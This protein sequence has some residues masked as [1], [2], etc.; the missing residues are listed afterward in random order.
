MRILRRFS[1]E[2]AGLVLSLLIVIPLLI[3]VFGSFKN[4][5]GA[6]RFTIVP[7]EIWHFSNYTHVYVEGG[8]DKALKN[9][10][11]ITVASV[12]VTIFASVLCA[13]YL[14]RKADR[15]TKWLRSLFLLGLIIP[16][17]VIPTVKLLQTF[18]LSGSFL[19]IIALYAAINLSFSTFLY[20]GFIGS[21]PR[22]LDEAAIIDG[23][24]PYA[25]FFRIVLPL[26]LPATTTNI[27]ITATSVWNDFY[28]PLYFFNSS[29]KFTLPLSVYNFFGL[30]SRDWNYVFADLIITALP[31]T[32]LYLFMQRYIISGMTTGS[33]KG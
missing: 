4:S 27:V 12:I 13:F 18:H 24:G 16:M 9:S 3:V 32:F 20:D 19:G 5:E 31:V 8:I 10:T 1:A 11:I 26:L 28:L 22:E 7:P 23:C 6:M 21:I 33:V 15:L 29:A 14:A 17:S 2:F 25:L 30:Y